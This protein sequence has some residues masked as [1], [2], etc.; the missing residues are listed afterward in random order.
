M[1]L[2]EHIEGYF[3]GKYMERGWV[4]ELD[5]EETLQKAVVRAINEVIGSREDFLSILQVNIVTVLSE[6]YDKNTAEIDKRLDELQQEILQ[7]AISKSDYNTVVDEIYRL[8]E[9]KQNS[10]ADNAER[11]GKRR[12]IAEMEEFLCEQEYKMKEYDE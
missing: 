3:Y 1:C 6:E 12:R 7:L 10:L 11:Q 9:R 4:D 5:K 2:W 8:R